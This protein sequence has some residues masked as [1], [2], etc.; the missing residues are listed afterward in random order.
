MALKDWKKQTSWNK[1]A[2]KFTALQWNNYKKKRI[3]IIYK[4]QFW[5]EDFSLKRL[6]TK[7]FKSEKEALKFAKDYMRRH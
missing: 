1:Y 6:I 3:V 2:R 5:L 7:K 4:N